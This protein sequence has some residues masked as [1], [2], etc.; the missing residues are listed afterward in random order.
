MTPLTGGTMPAATATT[1]A[2]SSSGFGVQQGSPGAGGNALTTGSLGF[3][4]PLTAAFSGNSNVAPGQSAVF[5]NSGSLTGTSAPTT[6]GNGVPFQLSA[7]GD[8]LAAVAGTPAVAATPGSPGT[9]GVAAGPKQAVLPWGTP[10]QTSGGPW[11]PASESDLGRNR[12][13]VTMT[14]PELDRGWADGIPDRTIGRMAEE[15]Y[16]NYLNTG[17]LVLDIGTFYNQHSADQTSP[18]YAL[19]SRFQTWKGTEAIHYVDDGA[20]PFGPSGAGTPAIAAV[21]PT[22]ATPGTAAVAGTPGASGAMDWKTWQGLTPFQQAAWLTKNMAAGYSQPQ[23][24][25]GEQA[26]LASQ[27]VTRAPD[28]TQMTYGTLSPLQ[29]QSYG[30]TAQVFGQSPQEWLASQQRNWS[31][32]LAAPAGGAIGWA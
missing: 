16:Q 10:I 21:A 15:A 11:T 4:Q 17:Q 1:P 12:A 9:P 8:P 28:V 13:V 24:L 32:A 2:G 19:P 14:H 30:N 6:Q 23:V 25:A 20:N 27:G 22:A 31:P 26:A 5:A 18:A 3:E 7:T 29:Q